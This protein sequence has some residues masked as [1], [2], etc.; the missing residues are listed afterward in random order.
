MTAFLGLLED[1]GDERAHVLGRLRR[2]RDQEDEPGLDLAGIPRAR[3]HPLGQ[4]PPQRG[5]G[6][7]LTAADGQ[8][9]AP[10]VLAHETHLLRRL[11]QVSGPVP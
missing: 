8:D 1:P 7:K 10:P 2:H 9:E 11:A 5:T 3:R 6:T 4:M